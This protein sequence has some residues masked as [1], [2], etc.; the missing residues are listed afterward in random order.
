MN[1]TN[2]DST[3]TG[4]AEQPKATKLVKA[5]KEPK[6]ILP[7]GNSPADLIRAA[8]SGGADLDKLEKL[9]ALQE[10]YEVNEARK[11]FAS[12]FAHAQANISV[13]IKKKFNS[14]TNSK[15][16]DLGDII[17]SAKPIYTAEGFSVIFYEGETKTPESVRI[18]ADVLHTAGHKETYFYDVPLDGVGI[19][20]NPNMTKI[21][22][23]GS[24]TSYGQRYLMGMIWNIPRKDDDGN[25]AGAVP[26]EVIDEKQLSQLL[27]MLNSLNGDPKVNL[28][29]FLAYLKLEKLEDMRKSDYQK[30]IVAIEKKQKEQ[31]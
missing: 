24:S 9:L 4:I 13:V 19:K 12:S 29:S 6:E 1:N 22:A 27:D 7:Q 2:C 16:A 5:K 23:K 20:G 15:Y 11:I 14:Q 3:I 21:H 28:K 8:V 10:R 25:L 18:C 17:E 26:A 30:A 31:K